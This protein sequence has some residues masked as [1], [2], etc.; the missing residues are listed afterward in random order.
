MKYNLAIIGGGPSG[1]MAAGRAGE[2]GADV[3]LLEK[4]QRLGI[5][6]LA[7][8]GGRANISNLSSTR[9]LARSFGAS[10][11][12]LLSGLSRF[13]S[14]QLIDFFNSHGL[15]TKVED[16][17]RVFPVSN[18]AHD[19]LQVLV[20]YLASSGVDVKLK[21][22]VKQIIKKDQRIEKLILSDGREVV[23]Q[24]YIFCTGGK[25]YPTTGSTGDAYKWLKQLGH[26]VTPPR[27]AL[28]PIILKDKLVKNLEGLSLKA[29]QISCYLEKHKICSTVGDAIFTAS[30]LSGPA[31]LN[32]SEIIGR[33]ENKGLEIV[34]NFFPDS[35][36]GELD[37][38]LQTSFS[39]SNKM[40]R[41]ALGELV[42]PRLAEALLVRLGV[43]PDKKLNLI[44]REERKA[45]AH[46]LQEFRLAVFGMAGYDKAMVTAGGVSLKEVD[47]K[48]M[49]SKII[50][51]LY[52]AGEILDLNGPTGGYNLQ[53]S[54]TTGYVAGES[55]AS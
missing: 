19:V 9:D 7:T 36:F 54:W 35:D 40:V 13:G 45:L 50:E 48:T 15:K 8:G 12:W 32:L 41:N 46:L 44:S 39:A 49:R 23:A 18:S 43:N 6:L 28:T 10:G 27:P 31:V 17:G 33:E 5:K 30:G 22:E 34:L 42:P 24:K 11:S 29:V 4:N 26:Q 51:N 37:R 3:V 53:L 52:F 21:A 1:L 38:Q 25:S 14:E 16:N 2:L 20:E 47:P 55:A